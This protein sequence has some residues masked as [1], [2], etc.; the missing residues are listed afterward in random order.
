[1]CATS[2]CCSTLLRAGVLTPPPLLLI[3][4]LCYYQ[5][6]EFAIERGLRR[7]EAGAQ[8]GSPWPA[9]A[10]ICIHACIAASVEADAGMH[11]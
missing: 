8:G 3:S 2:T 7:V 5:A 1:M 6:L 9:A 10:G 11:L 4:Q